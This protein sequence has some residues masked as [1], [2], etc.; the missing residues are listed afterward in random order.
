[1]T[2]LLLQEDMQNRKEELR[3]IIEQTGEELGRKTEEVLTISSM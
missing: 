3:K 1:M 2:E